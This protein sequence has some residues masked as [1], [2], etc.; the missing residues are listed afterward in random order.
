MPRRPYLTEMLTAVVA[1][2]RRHK[3]LT[4]SKEEGGAGG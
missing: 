2:S 4:S 1:G 3:W